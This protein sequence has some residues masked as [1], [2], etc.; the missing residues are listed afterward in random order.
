MKAQPPINDAGFASVVDILAKAG[1]T[2]DPVRLGIAD[3]TPMQQLRVM[4]SRLMGYSP[5]RV[6]WPDGASALMPLPP[7]AS[8]PAPAE[9]VR[10]YRQCKAA[11]ARQHTGDSHE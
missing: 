9:I 11:P 4:T 3:L 6:T 8:T 2:Q 7:G 1:F 5:V 10:A